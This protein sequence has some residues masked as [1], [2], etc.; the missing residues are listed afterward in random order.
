MDKK[1]ALAKSPDNLPAESKEQKLPAKVNPVEELELEIIR[2]LKDAGTLDLTNV[3]K[4]YLIKPINDNEVEIRPDGLLY[5]SWT[6]YVSRLMDAFGPTGWAMIPRGMPRTTDKSIIWAFYLII[7][8]KFCG[9][10]IG[11]QE[12]FA[13]NPT[14]SYTDACE[15]AKSNALM[16]LCKGLGIGLELWKPSFIRAWKKKYAESYKEQT[17]WG[18]KTKWKRRGDDAEQP[19][20]QESEQAESPAKPTKKAANKA[21]LD[22]SPTAGPTKSEPEAEPAPVDKKDEKDGLI[23]LL[24]R[25]LEKEG[26]K[27]PKFKEFLYGFQTTGKRRKEFVGYN[28]FKKLSFHEGKQGDL[29]TLLVYLDSAIK[30]FKNSEYYEPPAQ[31]KKKE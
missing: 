22:E 29:K 15:G 3:Q 14:M 27:T 28:N 7:K 21:A 10:A 30:E 1:D 23:D 9:V 17:K 12:Y 2:G 26:I 8:G 20:I 5:C 31:E 6:T 4:E 16:R 13:N 19:E 24:K 18:E 11:E 25:K